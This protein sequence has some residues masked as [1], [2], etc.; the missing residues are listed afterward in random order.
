MYRPIGCHYVAVTSPK[1]DSRALSLL[2]Y[3]VFP[4]ELST[5]GR[6][7]FERCRSVFAFASFIAPMIFARVRS[8]ISIERLDV[9]ALSFTRQ[10]DDFRALSLLSHSVFLLDFSPAS[11]TIYLSVAAP[12]LPSLSP[13]RWMILARVRSFMSIDRL[14]VTA[15]AFT[16]HQ[17]DSR[18]LLLIDL[19][20]FLLGLSLEYQEAAHRRWPLWTRLE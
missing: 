1:D 4:L 10:Q 18:A 12:S 3:S 11:R 6:T 19:L 14:D 2:S 16:R 7:I 13:E 5:A 17:D 9:S 15:L 20:M 8:L